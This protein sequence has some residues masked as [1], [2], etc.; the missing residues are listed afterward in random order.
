MFFVWFKALMPMLMP[1]THLSF[2]L[3]Q[4][5]SVANSLWLDE[6]KN[7]KG[8]RTFLSFLYST[9]NRSWQNPMESMLQSDNF[10]LSDTS[11]Q[12]IHSY[13]LCMF[14]STQH[15]VCT[16]APCNP[17][18]QYKG[19]SKTQLCAHL[20]RLS[21]AHTFN[22]VMII[23]KIIKKTWL[24]EWVSFITTLS[25]PK[26][27]APSSWRLESHTLHCGATASFK[28]NP[29]AWPWSMFPRFRTCWDDQHIFWPPL[30]DQ[31]EKQGRKKRLWS[32]EYENRQPL[33]RLKITQL[34][35]N[36][37]HWNT[38]YIYRIWC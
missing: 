17:P 29:L 3:D 37:I 1:N 36:G 33:A 20:P 15:E 22:N 19:H 23:Q 30:A 14:P 31:E 34:G 6:C 16:A 5:R 10:L 26:D 28:V 11:H 4:T 25:N 2:D 8:N 21:S 27:L 18:K 12:A 35:E 9:L 7:P 38:I 13:S 24:Q 32:L